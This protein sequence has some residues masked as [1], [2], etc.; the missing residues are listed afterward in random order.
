[1]NKIPKNNHIFIR[2]FISIAIVIMVIGFVGV[3]A[4]VKIIQKNY[5]NQQ[6]EINKRTA[7]TMSK[8]LKNQLDAG[9]SKEAVLSGFQEAINGSQT[10]EGYLCMFDH[11]AGEVICHP[12]PKVIGMALNKANIKF[13]S[14]TGKDHE[15]LFDAVSTTNPEGGILTFN[16]DQHSE[17]A[18]MIPV[19]GTDWKISVHEN[20]EQMNSKLSKL[21][22]ES[23]LYFLVIAL[24]I[25]VLSTIASRRV[26]AGYENKIIEQKE[27]IEKQ[28]EELEAKVKERTQELERA[29]F[30]LANIDKAKSDFLSIIS[31]ELR[32]PLNGII[33]FTDI[34]AEDLKGTDQEE[35]ITNLKTSG[36]RLLRFSDTALLITELSAERYEM[37]FEKVDPIAL[38]KTVKEDFDARLAKKNIHFKIDCPDE[39]TL[40][41]M[42]SLIKKCFE[43]I[44]DNALKYTPEGGTIKISSRIKDQQFEMEIKD[45]GSGFSE[46][47]L[48]K[49]F[50]YFGADKVMH[51]AEGFGLGLA[52]CKLIIKAHEGK[53]DIANCDTGGALVRLIFKI[54]N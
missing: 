37:Q 27:L 19:E 23:Y 45:S 6:L 12:D 49:L 15:Q 9:L 53:I 24:L 26:S 29:N 21:K 40:M 48:K 32:T 1:M 34:L 47:A 3:S 11:V 42:P 18:F 46:E 10:D 16:K 30:K 2:N 25:S 14:S 43:N 39:M 4:F 52:A 33:G 7:E 28:N 50:D 22:R 31:H 20:M 36:M 44:L 5:V 17:I 54:E 38:L 51:H 35:Y 41:L 8:V 13:L